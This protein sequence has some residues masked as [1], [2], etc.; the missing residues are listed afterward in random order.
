MQSV[1]FHCYC[2][3]SCS[4]LLSAAEQ[5]ACVKNLKAPEEWK[6]PERE[7]DVLSQQKKNDRH[8]IS[9]LQ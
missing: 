7:I 2:N 4:K 9:K 5:C 6:P 8:S 1:C 3:S